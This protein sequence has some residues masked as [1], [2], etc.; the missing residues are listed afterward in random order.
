MAGEE[1]YGHSELERCLPMIAAHI[2]AQ[3]FNRELLVAMEPSDSLENI[4]STQVDWVPIEPCPRD[5]E[6]HQFLYWLDS[7][8]KLFSV[9]SPAHP[10]KKEQRLL[11]CVK[12]VGFLSPKL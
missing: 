8:V 3:R 11:T 2:E 9:V 1:E 7:M 10:P 12:I 5:L 6:Y 4:R